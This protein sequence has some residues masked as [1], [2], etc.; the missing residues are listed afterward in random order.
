MSQNSKFL[1]PNSLFTCQ[2]TRGACPRRGVSVSGEAGT[3][4]AL[5]GLSTTFF[6]LPKVFFGAP[7]RAFLPGAE[8]RTYLDSL[9]LSTTFFVFF[10]K[11]LF[12]PASLR[13]SGFARLRETFRPAAARTGYAPL[14]PRCQR[15]LRV[16]FVFFSFPFVSAMFSVPLRAKEKYRSSLLLRSVAS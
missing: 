8:A 3:Y 6:Q 2:R 9:S 12:R 1:L 10:F 7:R 11:K 4:P 16:F 13:L 14:S 15:L 5:F